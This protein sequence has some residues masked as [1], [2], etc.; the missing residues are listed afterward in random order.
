MSGPARGAGRLLG[1]E[2]FRFTTRPEPTRAKV[3]GVFLIIGGVVVALAVVLVASM[4]WSLVRPAHTGMDHTVTAARAKAKPI[5]EAR[6]AAQVS[7]IAPVLGQPSLRAFVD[8]CEP[9]NQGSW[10]PDV[11]CERAYYLFYAADQVPTGFQAPDLGPRVLQA[12]SWEAQQ[13]ESCDYTGTG[14]TSVCFRWSTNYLQVTRNSTLSEPSLPVLGAG[15]VD[16]NES[17]G[18]EELRG[19]ARSNPLGVVVLYRTQYFY[20]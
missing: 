5:A 20:G 3:L 8:W 13:H 14:Q 16:E 2:P 11:M 4:V 19:T 7:A 6:V 10:S 17:E 9:A 12:G 18:Y 1:G 15:L